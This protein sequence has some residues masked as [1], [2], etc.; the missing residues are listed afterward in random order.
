MNVVADDLMASVEATR[1]ADAVA[2]AEAKI[3]LW[4]ADRARQ[5]HSDL[6]FDEVAAIVRSSAAPEV[7]EALIRPAGV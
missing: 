1:N 3:G 6:S 5:A 7:A 4:M 2:N